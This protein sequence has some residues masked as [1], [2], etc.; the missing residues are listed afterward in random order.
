MQGSVIPKAPASPGTAAPTPHRNGWL[1]ARRHEALLHREAT[2]KSQY[3]SSQLPFSPK[4]F[5]LI[6]MHFP[7]FAF[8]K[9]IIV[10]NDDRRLQFALGV[11]NLSLKCNL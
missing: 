3:F 6:N 1:E 9:S 10:F 5:D 7:L 4:P 2:H 8:Y 11:R